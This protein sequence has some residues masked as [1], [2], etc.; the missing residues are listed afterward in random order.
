MSTEKFTLM[1]VCTVAKG[2][3]F[4]PEARRCLYCTASW[5]VATERTAS[6]F[7]YSHWEMVS[8][9]PQSQIFHAKQRLRRKICIAFVRR[10][11]NTLIATLDTFPQNIPAKGL[12]QP[13][14]VPGLLTVLGSRSSKE[15]QYQ[16]LVLRKDYAFG[17]DFEDEPLSTVICVKHRTYT[18][19]ASLFHHRPYRVSHQSVCWFMSTFKTWLKNILFLPPLVPCPLP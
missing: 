15:Q 13:K 8:P 6:L 4:W 14:G 19:D 2:A 17:F 16:F 18:G 10:I 7:Y 1:S 9:T 11:P 3:L 12:S 5:Y